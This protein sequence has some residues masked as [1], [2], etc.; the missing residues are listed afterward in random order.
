M[1]LSSEQSQ[2]G[3]AVHSSSAGFRSPILMWEVTILTTIFCNVHPSAAQQAISQAFSSIHHLNI[4]GMSENVG[5]I[6]NEI[7]I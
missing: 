6:P 2:I 4:F 5:Y 3:T 1:M 7:A